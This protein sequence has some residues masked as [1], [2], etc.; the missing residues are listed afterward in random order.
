MKKMPDLRLQM[1][2]V[3]DKTGRLA[4]LGLITTI[5]LILSYIE[6]LIPVLPGIPGVKLGLANLAI[7][8]TLYRYNLRDACFVSVMR[9]LI[10]GFMFGNLM[11]IAFS[12][13]GGFLSLFVMYLLKRFQVFQLIGVSAAGGCAHN[14]GQLLVACFAVGA[15][16]LLYYLPVLLVSGVI[17]GLLIGIAGELLIRRVP[18]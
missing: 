8:F 5:A 12:L 7:L 1:E 10:S 17:T 9:I 3:M 6:S 18:R 11:S 15:A 2:R 16:P 4:V 13:A 14:I